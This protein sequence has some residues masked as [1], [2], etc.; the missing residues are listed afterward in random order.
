MHCIVFNYLT[1]H[2]IVYQF[3]RVLT[4]SCQQRCTV[5]EI[6]T[7]EDVPQSLSMTGPSALGLWGDQSCS[8]AN[9]ELLLCQPTSSQYTQHDHR[10]YNSYVIETQ[11]CAHRLFRKNLES[12]FMEA[13]SCD[14]GQNR[15]FRSN[16]CSEKL[17]YIDVQTCIYACHL[18]VTNKLN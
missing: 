10:S 18:S 5:W 15:Q 6:L 1:M 9:F 4:S 8:Q 14:P 2:C 3:I 11:M 7:P 13:R 16:W 12:I 17:L